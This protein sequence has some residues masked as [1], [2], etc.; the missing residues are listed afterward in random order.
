MVY[1]LC[2][3][4]MHAPGLVKAAQKEVGDK[5]AAMSIQHEPG[6]LVLQCSDVGLY[7]QSVLKS[8]IS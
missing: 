4:R 6:T 5:A 3:V 7:I 1:H 2:Q 8:L